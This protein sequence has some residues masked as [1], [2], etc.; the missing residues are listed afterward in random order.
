MKSEP[1]PADDARQH[2][3]HQ[4]GAHR[5]VPGMRHQ[6]EP[7]PAEMAARCRTET[8]V[9]DWRERLV[10]SKCGSQQIDMVVS[11]NRRQSDG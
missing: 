1:G 4:L 3:R 5:T 7:D 10:C 8:A 9:P 6:V 2:R 11:G